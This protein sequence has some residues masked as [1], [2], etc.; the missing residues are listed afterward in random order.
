[1]EAFDQSA[2][3]R[4]GVSSVAKES[5]TRIRRRA[6]PAEFQQSIPCLSLPALE[7][8]SYSSKGTNRIRHIHIRREKRP[9]PRHTKSDVMTPAGRLKCFSRIILYP[10]HGY[11]QIR[12]RTRANRTRSVYRE[13]ILFV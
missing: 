13:P 12:L 4:C 7:G 9:P 8:R 6:R 11:L 2:G 3:S 1:M 5:A 10:L